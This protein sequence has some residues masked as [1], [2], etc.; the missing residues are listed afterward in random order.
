MRILRKINKNSALILIITLVLIL[1]PQLLW[2]KLFI[3]GGDDSR[4]YYIFPKQFLDNFVFKISSDNILGTIAGYSPRSF[5][6]PVIYIIFLLK[7]I[8]F[9]NVQLLMYGLNLGLGFLFFYLFLGIWIKNNENYKI[10]IKI[11]SS[12][13]YIF[14]TYLI[15][16]LYVN[17]LLAVYLVFTIP[18]SLYFFLK[19]LERKNIFLLLLSPLVFSIFG[20]TFNTLPWSAAAFIVLSPVFLYKFWEQKKIFILYLLIFSFVTILLNF[21]WILPL[22]YSYFNKTG[23]VSALEYYSSEQFKTSSGNLIK[24]V[25]GIFSQLNTVF[26]ERDTTIIKDFSVLIFLKEIFI[27][28]IVSAG[29]SI[30]KTEVVLRKYYLIS[31]SCLLLAFFFFS[32]SFG[33]WSVNI[34]IFLNEKIPFF[35]MFRNMYDKFS[36]ALA[37]SYAF[38]FAISAVI[39]VER[40]RNKRYV[41]MFLTLL[42]IIIFVNAHSFIFQVDNNTKTFNTISG[43]FRKEFYDLV[44]YT[45]SIN[46][47]SRFAWM[48]LNYPSYAYMEDAKNKGHFYF[49]TS[50]LSIITGKVDYTG[51]LSF[52]TGFDPDLG[53]KIFKAIEGKEYSYV[54]KTFQKLNINYI[55]DNKEKLPNEAKN[56]LYSGNMLQIQ[57]KDFRNAILGKEIKNFGNTYTLYEIKP[58]FKSNLFYLTDSRDSSYDKYK[59]VKFTQKS[60][61]EYSIVLEH[62]KGKQLLIFQDLYNKGWILYLNGS[63]NNILYQKDKNISLHE[64]FANGWFINTNEIRKQFDKGFYTENTDGSINVNLT[65][66]LYP[67]KLVYIGMTISII[68]LLVIALLEIYYLFKN[69]KINNL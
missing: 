37:F 64:N 48:P 16:T 41:Q 57:D 33:N 50:P 28:V 49:G 18:C 2:G 20:S 11:V 30:R 8:P 35:S 43:I 23:S 60:N 59:Y 14:S 54:G 25:S 56:F 17:Q 69:I 31:L 63:K 12:F 51:Y 53:G 42:L 4:L 65:L 52:G 3:V 19:A 46:P 21:H 40:I 58:T 1:I 13:F 7:Q 22:F 10:Y 9:L 27:L 68:T 6:A 38:A 15:N 62:I 39:I 29:I 32:P 24:G 45:Q 36:F 34:F 66:D 67:Q 47:G 26:N 5:L 61:S 55:I 44:E